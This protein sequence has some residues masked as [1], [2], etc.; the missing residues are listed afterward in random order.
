M[1]D[2]NE[3]QLNGLKRI[4]AWLDRE[5]SNS[6][7]SAGNSDPDGPR[8]ETFEDRVMQLRRIREEIPHYIFEANTHQSG[9]R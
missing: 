7:K 1:K 2:W 8:I 4:A 5:I 3:R 9:D 6:L